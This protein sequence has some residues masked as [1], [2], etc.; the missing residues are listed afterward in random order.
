[1]IDSLPIEI[2]FVAAAAY[3]FDLVELVMS[4]IWSY[5]C[6]LQCIELAKE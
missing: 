1:M 3:E 5:I 6:M 2:L 4:I